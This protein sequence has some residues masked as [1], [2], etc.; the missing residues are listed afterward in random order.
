[1]SVIN[2]SYGFGGYCF[3][4]N[5]ATNEAFGAGVVLV[6]AGGNDFLDENLSDST[7]AADPHVITVAAL[8]PDYSSAE[9]S[10]ANPTVD[11]SAPGVSI[12]TATPTA[13]DNDGTP[14]GYTAV[15]GTSYS[16]PITA[17]AAAW[18][19]ADRPWLDQTQVTDLVRYSAVDVGARG[20]DRDYG[21]GAVDMASILSSSAP[22]SDPLEP[23]DDIE[24]INGTRFRGA[25]RPIWKGA[26]SRRL[27]GRLD[28]F[29]DPVDVYRVVVP[30][31]TSVRFTVTPRYGDPDLEVYSAVAHTVY[32]RRGLIVHSYRSGSR[33]D[34]AAITNHAGSRRLAY[35]CIFVPSG[36][37]S[38]DAGYSLSVRRLR[39]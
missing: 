26:R 21:F 6:A 18:A 17:A 23:N 5:V 24:W 2:M 28:E 7:P 14:D 38:I 3:A 12:L 20:W 10:N 30:G 13:F 25:D 36:A 9:F 1:V 39:R 4:H 37:R 32:S 27:S 34:Q 33:R 29:E 16:A 22:S 19:I 35:V 8:N 31:R 15:D 11:V